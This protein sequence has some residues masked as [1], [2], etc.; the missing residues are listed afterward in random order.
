MYRID[1][2]I[3]GVAAIGILS[4]M[5]FVFNYNDLSWKGNVSSYMLIFSQ[6][7]LISAMIF[8]IRHEN[9]KQ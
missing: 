3:I 1:I 8:S 4:I 9:K 7:C 2:F 5:C 6:L